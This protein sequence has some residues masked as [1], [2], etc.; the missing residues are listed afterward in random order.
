MR[1]PVVVACLACLVLAAP[2]PGA[3]QH[4]DVTVFAGAAF[5]ILDGKLVLRAP[6][7]PTLPGVEITPNG[8]PELRTDGGPVYGVAV[9]LEFGVLAIEG[10]FDATNV[11]FEVTGARYDLR[12]TQPPLEGL[13]ASLTIGNGR[14]DV[15]QLNLISANLRLRTPGP[16]GLIVSGGL[17]YLPDIEVTGS[18]P[19]DF[20]INGQPAL[21]T[22]DPQITLVAT[23]EQSGD[24]W[25]LNAGVGIR[26]GGGRL[27]FVAEAR[28]FYFGDYEMHFAVDDP[29]PFVPELAE[30][31]STFRFEPVFLNAQAGLV[32]RF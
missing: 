32:F 6:G 10:R 25:G 17:S 31:L 23:P 30:S 21:P 1:E 2:S 16:I 29:L 28:L 20:Q 18:V 8:T 11:G 19:L 27:A 26:V 22:L 12:A 24:R 15:K 7:A 3:A 14:L 4:L 9:A 5:P 13:A